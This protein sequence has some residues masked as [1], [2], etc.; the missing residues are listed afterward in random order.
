[1]LDG[2]VDAVSGEGL[3]GKP[4]A[5]AGFSEEDEVYV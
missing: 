4:A 3:A 2:G 5:D 1:V